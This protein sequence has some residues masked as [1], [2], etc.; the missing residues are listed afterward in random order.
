M[1]DH[2]GHSKALEML[3]ATPAILAVASLCMLGGCKYTDILTEHIEDPTN[4]TVNNNMEPL[5]KDVEN[6]KKDET[7]VSTHENTSKKLDKQTEEL[8]VYDKN[9]P[10]NGPTDKR[11]Q[12][13]SSSHTEAATQGSKNSKNKKGKSKKPK[14]SKKQSA[15]QSGTKKTTKKTRTQSTSSKSEDGD[16]KSKI[17]GKTATGGKGGKA[18]VYDDGTYKNLPDNVRTVAAAGQ[19]A[20][21]VQM[22]SGASGRHLVAADSAWLSRV[23]KFGAFENEGTENI[24]AGWSGDNDQNSSGSAKNAKVSTIIKA[25]PDVVLVDGSDDDSNLSSSD[26]KKLTKQ[27]INVVVMPELGSVFTTDANITKAAKI[28]GNLL[29]DATSSYSS[30]MAKS[31]ISYH[32][33]IIA[34]DADY[35]YKPGYVYKYQTGEP[36]TGSSKQGAITTAFVDH[37]TTTTQGRVRARRNYT[38]Y[39]SP[40]Y[41]DGEFIDVS[42]GVGMSVYGTGYALMDYYFQLGGLVNNSYQRVK[43][44]ETAAY[45]IVAGQDARGILSVTAANRET[46]SALWYAM[47][48]DT[49]AITIGD[50]SYPALVARDSD[51]AKTIQTSANKTNGLYNIGQKYRI[52][53]MP[54]G[55]SGN[56]ADGTVESF[57]IRSWASVCLTTSDP[58]GSDEDSL[59]DSIQ[60]FYTSFY[61]ADK[62]KVSNRFKRSIYNPLRASCPRS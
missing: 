46:P 28:V 31:F 33:Q 21:L 27:G 47:T 59:N 7:R 23:K 15:K 58:S 36:T 13:D 42:D 55:L 8:P 10:D 16:G 1:R 2:K 38:S 18:Q 40:L 26:R 44:A 17:S 53:I 24:V 3:R 61:R 52:Y 37:M 34:K 14:K 30:Q 5:Y 48:S 9:A 35:W 56:W 11:I 41:L 20:S 51:I 12:S 29:S 39:G 43:P 32:D 19:Y 57:L 60:D 6:A 25:K 50:D 49:E 62:T 54:T 45:P 22:F 4:G